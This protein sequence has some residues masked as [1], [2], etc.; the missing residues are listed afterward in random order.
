MPSLAGKVMSFRTNNTLGTGHCGSAGSTGKMKKIL[1]S[2][3]VGIASG[4]LLASAA[5]KVPSCSDDYA[6]KEVVK[7]AEKAR[8]AHIDMLRKMGREATFE[9]GNIYEIETVSRDPETKI[10]KCTAKVSA[11]SN[12]GALAQP[13]KMTYQLGTYDDTGENYVK[14]KLAP[15]K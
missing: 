13:V 14:A 12:W 15:N 9:I 8:M 4:P 3:A 11:K 7:A 10:T 6:K 1:L 5:G 2:L